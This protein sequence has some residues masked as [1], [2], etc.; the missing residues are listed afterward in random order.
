MG[1]G[2][3]VQHCV[4]NPKIALSLSFPLPF[5][6]SPFP[7]FPPKSGIPPPPPRSMWTKKMLQGMHVGYLCE[8]RVPPQFRARSDNCS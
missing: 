6:L 2:Q 1:K 8:Q 3:N 5:F 4:Q 7:S